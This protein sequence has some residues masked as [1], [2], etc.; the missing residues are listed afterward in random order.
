MADSDSFNVEKDSVI[1][2]FADDGEIKTIDEDAAGASDKPKPS[3]GDDEKPEGKKPKAESKPKADDADDA[4]DKDKGG[5]AD[6]KSKD[7]KTDDDDEDEDDDKPKGKKG[8]EARKQQLNDEIRNLVS[9]KR[10]LQT[11]IAQGL[12]QAKPLKTIDEL[13]DEGMTDDQARIEMNRQELER[14]RL[15]QARTDLNNDVE[16]QSQRVFLD[17][18]WT[19]PDNKDEYDQ[20]LAQKAAAAYASISGIQIDDDT[21]QITNANVLPYTFYKTLQDFFSDG[22]KKGEIRGKAAARK[23]ASRAQAPGATTVAKTTVDDPVLAA[24]LKDAPEIK[25]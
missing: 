12:S 6:D 3:D 24:L 8:A 17:F 2:P 5:D 9:Q 15:I 1:D 25:K 4:D 22:Q 23:Q 19:D 21:K 13:K 20:T 11:E 7:G 10:Q 14:D 18:P 16:T